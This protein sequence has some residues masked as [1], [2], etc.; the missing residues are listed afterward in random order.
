MDAILTRSGGGE[1]FRRED[2]VITI[3]GELP[4]ISAFRLEVE[5][6]WPG[7]RAHSHDDQVDAFF[8]L[9]GEAMF[10]RGEGVAQAPAGTF[11]A[12][13]PGVRHGVAHEGGRVVLLNVHGPDAGFAESIRRL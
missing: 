10:V 3:L 11:Q 6:D 4:E 9:D 8:V 13:L 12:A 5:P 7:I 2:R 1:S